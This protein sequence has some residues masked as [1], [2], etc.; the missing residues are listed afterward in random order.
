MRSDLA[1]R[2]IGRVLLAASLW[3]VAARLWISTGLARAFGGFEKG[4][5]YYLASAAFGIKM[6]LLALI[7]V[8]EAWPM[9]TFVRWRLALG[10]DRPVALVSAALLGTISFVQAGLVVLM[11][12][13][14]TAMARGLG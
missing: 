3:G 1:R 14:A 4:T 13:A 9:A 6:A 2:G 11:V 7:L 10:R 5:A 8:L 12:F